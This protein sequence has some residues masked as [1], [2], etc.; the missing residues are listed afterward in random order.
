MNFVHTFLD[1][2]VGVAAITV[3]VVVGQDNIKK[4]TITDLQDLV[5]VLTQKIDT[6]EETVNKYIEENQELKETIDGYT[7]LVR[8]GYLTGFGRPR[9]RN[10]STSAKTTTNRKP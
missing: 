8:E 10:S 4:R 9:G 2:L 1:I 5:V 3:A 7:E 6:L